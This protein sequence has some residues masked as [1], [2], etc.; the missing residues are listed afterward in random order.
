M[1]VLITGSSGTGK[2]T[3]IKE[4]KRRGYTAIDGDEEPGLSRLEIQETGEPTDWPD[5]FVD[6]SFY[7]WNLNET[8]LKQ[9]L[10]KDETV[11][12]GTISGNQADYYSLFEKIIV[13]TVSPEEHL[14]RMKTRLP[15]FVE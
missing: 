4:L 6:W 10:Q 11:F 12:F 3:V 9:L 13:L 15:S 5:G 2:S 8:V 7:A 14:R 1:N